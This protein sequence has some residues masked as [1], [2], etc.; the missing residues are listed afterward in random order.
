[1]YAANP[2]SYVSLY[3][4]SSDP[5]LQ[6]KLYSPWITLSNTTSWRNSEI[7]TPKTF[8]RRNSKKFRTARRGREQNKNIS[9]FLFNNEYVERKKSLIYKI[10]NVVM[11]GL[12]YEESAIKETRKTTQ[13]QNPLMNN[14]VNSL[15]SSIP[16]NTETDFGTRNLV[17]SIAFYPFSF[18]FTDECEQ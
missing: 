6:N 1:M 4:S 14:R 5:K 16:G 12:F 3:S 11:N 10:V 15:F 7:F 8:S 18:D 13:I 17:Q 2:L 9:P